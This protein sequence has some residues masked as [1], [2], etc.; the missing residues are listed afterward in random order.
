MPKNI[1]L[2]SDGTGNS[3]AK[4]LKTNVWRVYESLDLT[5]PDEQVACYDDGVGT[6]SFAPLALLG[7]A[8][9]I[10]LRRNV[11]R[12]YRFLCEHYDPGDRIYLFGFSRGAFTVR[13]LLGLICD[14]GIIRTRPTMKVAG[15]T[16]VPEGLPAG[17][18][19][20]D[21]A[22][23]VA[24]ADAVADFAGVVYGTELYRLSAWAYRE[25]R[26]KFDHTRGLVGPARAARDAIFRIPEDAR[27]LPRYDRSRNHQ[28]GTIDID[29]VG[30][31][32][33]VDAYGMPVDELA[34]GIDEWVWPLTM[35]DAILPPQV[36]RAC[37]VLALDDERNTFH[38][39]LWDETNEDAN[40]STHVSDERLSQVWFA[41]MHAN[42]GG[43]YADDALAYVS[44]KWMTEQAMDDTRH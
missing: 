2:L 39:V 4:L 44:L 41:G 19:I 11:L 25:Y 35:R 34:D 9:G 5:N 43:G 6:S 29:F 18:V 26:K 31:W 36:K 42:V 3:A 16:G 32:D 22:G 38:P 10:G 27:G 37:H 23:G 21:V 24:V 7:G 30:V 33:T 15:A 13:V 12:L 8:L 40:I 20:D 17:F 1:V 14:Q 28:P